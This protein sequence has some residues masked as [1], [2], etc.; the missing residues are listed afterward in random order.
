MLLNPFSLIWSSGQWG[1]FS[2]GETGSSCLSTECNTK[3]QCIFLLQL[4][5]VQPLTCPGYKCCPPLHPVVM[6]KGDW[7]H[8]A[9]VVVLS[10][11]QAAK[12]LQRKAF[13]VQESPVFYSV[14]LIPSLVLHDEKWLM[15]GSLFWS[16]WLLSVASSCS[17]KV[18]SL[19]CLSCIQDVNSFHLVLAVGL[20]T[21]RKP[22]LKT[23]KQSTMK[24]RIS[25]SH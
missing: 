10:L 5:V 22:D 1:V 14:L 7:L 8:V 18:S 13:A 12:L 2:G 23:L 3:S 9:S 16:N 15:L 19:S 4:L 25:S 17:S 11:V 21:F 20:Q 6:Q 24:G